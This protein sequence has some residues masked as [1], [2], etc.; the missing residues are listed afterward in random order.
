[1]GL[2]EDLVFANFA[3][4][5]LLR[6]AE[7]IGPK[8]Y[9]LERERGR[10]LAG[11]RITRHLGQLTSSK[12]KGALGAPRAFICYEG[13]E[14]TRPQKL[15]ARKRKGLRRTG[16]WTA[17]RAEKITLSKEKGAAGAP[18]S[19]IFYEGRRIDRLQNYTIERERGRRRTGPGLP[20]T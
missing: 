9:T 4:L 12:E 13:C 2:S 7:S 14:I 16:A 6:G 1:M 18:R 8:N 15:H 19:L 11:A 3:L 17:R 20:G 5:S 10:R